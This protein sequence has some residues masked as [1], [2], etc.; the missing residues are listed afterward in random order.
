ML[1]LKG[2][3]L[4]IELA[5]ENE[6]SHSSDETLNSVLEVFQALSHPVR[7]EICQILMLR[8]HSVGTLC[9]LLDMKQ[10]KVSQQL[11]VLRKA[12]IVTARRDARRVIYALSNTKVRRILLVSIANLASAN[13]HS[14]SDL[15][16]KQQAG[17]FAEIL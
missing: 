5:M 3:V 7:L 15:D 8:Q 12:Q 13:S 14:L 1:S 10:Y 9:A 16:R 17:R 11:A 6:L 4:D 2:Q